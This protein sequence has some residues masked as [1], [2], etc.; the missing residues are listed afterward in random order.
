[1]RAEAVERAPSAVAADRSWSPHH[2]LPIALPLRIPKN[3]HK[4]S[5]I[6]M[7]V[8]DAISD[9]RV[10]I[11]VN[12]GEIYIFYIFFTTFQRLHSGVD[13][14]YYFWTLFSQ[15]FL[16]PT[17]S[18]DRWRW[19]PWAD[20]TTETQTHHTLWVHWNGEFTL[21]SLLSFIVNRMCT[22]ILQE[23]NATIDKST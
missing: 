14:V 12:L 22:F 5:K 20:R 7:C 16:L 1:M 3:K 13:G 9:T 21:L 6:I 18:I 17:W 2:A 23:H 10:V 19:V 11:M 8:N 15:L 4:Y